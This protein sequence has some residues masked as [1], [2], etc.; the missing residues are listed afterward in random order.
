[1]KDYWMNLFCE[2]ITPL[3]AALDRSLSGPFTI[4]T[5]LLCEML[6]SFIPSMSTRNQDY[7]ILK[8]YKIAPMQSAMTVQKQALNLTEFASPLYGMLTVDIPRDQTI[9]IP[10]TNPTTPTRDN[11]H[12]NRSKCHSIHIT[13]QTRFLWPVFYI[14][15]YYYTQDAT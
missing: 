15:L 2:L 3:R 7:Q 5:V 14:G 6:L 11:R 9:F 13:T 12:H 1:M 8:E 4:L 10:L